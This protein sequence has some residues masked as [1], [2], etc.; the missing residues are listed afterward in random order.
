VEEI[1]DVTA[2]L[3]IAFSVFPG[4]VITA[5]TVDPPTVVGGVVGSPTG[6]VT[7]T[8]PATS[9]TN[10][11]LATDV[12]WPLSTIPKP[13]V[14]ILGTSV[15]VPTTQSLATFPI[16]TNPVL[17]P[18][19]AEI[20][21]SYND[22]DEPAELTL[23]PPPIPALG[24]EAD[25][26]VPAI[27]NYFRQSATGSTPAQ[28]YN[29]AWSNSNTVRSD[30]K[31]GGSPKTGQDIYLAAA[32]HYLWAVF[33]T[34]ESPVSGPLAATT[35]VVGYDI[36]KFFGLNLDADPSQPASP[37]TLLSIQWGFEGHR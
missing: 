18:L 20:T 37:P 34:L 6:T 2:V 26:R 3:P 12:V 35:N 33:T 7:L 14:V 9:D 17:F 32:E 16:F 36:A 24:P 15:I 28:I 22:V 27:I 10:V 25:A 8:G 5:V 19:L 30:V 1:Q 23:M 21:A 29:S 4:P 11:T 13:Q 31:Y